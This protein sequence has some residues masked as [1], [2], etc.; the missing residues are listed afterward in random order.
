MPLWT[1]TELVRLT[2]DELCNLAGR[3]EGALAGFEPGTVVRLNQPQQ[4]PTRDGQPPPALLDALRCN[5]ID[6]VPSESG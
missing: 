2:R 3:I 6:L 1:I 4:H 5:L